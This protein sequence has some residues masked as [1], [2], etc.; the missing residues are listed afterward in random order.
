MGRLNMRRNTVKVHWI[1]LHFPLF[2][3][4]CDLQHTVDIDNIV[5]LDNRSNNLNSRTPHTNFGCILENMH[6]SL[7]LSPSPC[8][9]HYSHLQ[10][11]MPIILHSNLSAS[12]LPSHLQKFC[13]NLGRTRVYPGGCAP[14]LLSKIKHIESYWLHV[15]RNLSNS[16]H[17]VASNRSTRHYLQYEI[18]NRE[19]FSLLAIRLHLNTIQGNSI[20]HTDSIVLQ[21]GIWI[22]FF[23]YFNKLER[24]V[25][26]EPTVHIL[27]VKDQTFRQVHIF[28]AL[29]EVNRLEGKKLSQ[30]YSFS[31]F[32]V[33]CSR[34]QNGYLTIAT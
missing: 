33:P 24:L 16:F 22:L 17:L 9:V 15:T 30:F 6:H 5:S 14:C 21:N 11:L 29:I 23:S 34:L 19:K 26:I 32:T 10:L 31:H 28:F 1:F 20:S 27:I 3:L 4:I 8:H 7:F 18:P 25:L 2:F 12:Q 13:S